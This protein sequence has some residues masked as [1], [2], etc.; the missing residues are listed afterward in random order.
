MSFSKLLNKQMT[1]YERKRTADVYG[2]H[3][4]TLEEQAVRRCT[5]QRASANEVIA[6]GAVGVALSHKIYCEPIDIDP[7][8]VIVADGKRYEVIHANDVQG[9]GKVM[10]VDVLQLEGGGEGL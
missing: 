10:Q 5:V 4:E 7:G 1:V 3:T 9:R 8:S 2:G 6:R